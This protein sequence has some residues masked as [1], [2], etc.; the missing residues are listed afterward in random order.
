MSIERALVATAE[1]IGWSLSADAVD[2]MAARLEG[3]PADEVLGALGRCADECRGRLAL[4]DILERVPSWQ[5]VRPLSADEAWEKALE[6]R[7]WDESLTI[8]S[9]CAIVRAFPYA[10][11]QEGDKVAA[12]R[13]FIDAYRR[14]VEKPDAFDTYVTEGTD[15]ASRVA[16]ISE[17]IQDG[18]LSQSS[19]LLLPNPESAPPMD[20]ATGERKLGGLVADMTARRA[21]EREETRRKHEERKVARRREAREGQ[22][23]PNDILARRGNAR[24]VRTPAG[25]APAP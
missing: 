2:L 5:A 20:R 8:V 22:L 9:T 25:A 21:A 14:E 10:I 4:A 16:V 7:L 12:R 15:K 1:V 23:S 3:F 24:R 6:A 19:A 13:A 17:A 11:W 18:R